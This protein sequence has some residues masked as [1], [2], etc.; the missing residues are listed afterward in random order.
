M[1][2]PLGSLDDYG[3]GVEPRWGPLEAKIAKA[4]KKH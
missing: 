3:G 2:C 1:Q 4:S